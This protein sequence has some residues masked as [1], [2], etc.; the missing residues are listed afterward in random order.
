MTVTVEPRRGG[1][2]IVGS[3]GGGKGGGSSRTPVETPDS[4]HNSAYAAVLDVIGNGEMYGPVHRDQ[5]LRDVFLDGTP[6]QNEDGSLNFSQVQADYRVGTVDQEHIAGFPASANTIG[7][8]AEIKTD[9][10]WV[11]AI[12]N[13][14]LSAVRVTMYVPRLVQALESGKNAGDRVGYRV[15]YAIDLAV[16]GGSFQEVVRSA[17]DGK[18]SNGYTRTHRLD[19]PA[20]ASSWT[21]RAR[22]ITPEA[23][24]AAISDSISVQSYAEVIDG[25]FRHPMTAMMGIKI[26][27]E[28][29]QAI[30]TRAYRWRG[31]IIRIPSNYDPI[32]RTYAGVWD[33]TFKRGWSNNPAW[34]YYDMLTSR[35]YGL[36]DR[37][38]ASMID[39]Y[40]LYQIGAYCDQLVPDGQGGVEPRFVCNVY[41]QSAADALRVLNDLTS[42]FRGMAYWANGQVVASVDAPSD[43]IYTYTNA[44]VVGGRFEYA[45]ADLRTLKTVALVSW[46]DPS[47]FYRPKVEVVEDEDGIRRYGIRKTEVVAFGC[48]SRG[49]AQRVGLYQL[50]TSRMESGGLT[51]SVGLDGV[52]PQPGSIVRVADRNRAGRHIGGR[53]RQATAGTVTVDREH[54]IKAGDFLT[55]NLASGL[56]ETRAV[57][58]VSGRV[59]TVFPEFSQAPEPESVWSVDA[60]DLVTQHARILSVKEAGGIV[61]DVSAVLHHP[62]KFDAIDNGVRLDPL[63]V[64]VVPPRVQTAPTN[65]RIE[66]HYTIHQGTTR[67]Y[68]EISWDAAEHA[69]LYDVQWRRDN[70]DWVLVPRTGSRLVE[71]P[72]IYAGTYTVRVRA[73]NALDVPSLWA[74]STATLLDGLVGSPP[75]VTSL[76]AAGETL[77][78]RLTWAYPTTPNIVER[79]QIWSSETQQ[80]DSGRVLTNLAYPDTTYTLGNQRAGV[81]QWFWARLVDKNGLPG[82][83]YPGESESGVRGSADIDSGPILDLI[84][85]DVLSSAW[86]QQMAERVE[87]ID[88]R[89]LALRA[90]AGAADEL[91]QRVRADVER[92]RQQIAGA[93]KTIQKHAEDLR[94]Q[95]DQLV[96]NAADI[97]QVAADRV[98][99]DQ[100]QADAL[101]VETAA[102][103]VVQQQHAEDIAGNAEATRRVAADLLLENQGRTEQV[104]QEAALRVAGD[105][106]QADA[107]AAEGANR[108]AGDLAQAGALADAR[109]ELQDAIDGLAERVSDAAGDFSGLSARLT[110]EITDRTQ[111]AQAL[112]DDVL[113]NAS[114]IESAQAGLGDAVAR[115]T[116]AEQLQVDHAAQLLQLNVKADDASSGIDLLRDVQADQALNMLALRTDVDGNAATANQLLQ[117]T[118]ELSVAQS[119]LAV[120]A[121]NLEARADSLTEVADDH[122]LELLRLRASE[123]DAEGMYTS[124][125]RADARQVQRMERLQLQADGQQSQIEDIATVQVGH[126]ERI[127]TVETQAASVLSRVQVVETATETQASRLETVERQSGETSSRVAQMQIA[128]ESQASLLAD[129]RTDV[130]GNTSTAAQLLQTTNEL[131][132]QQTQLET[133]VG[134]AESQLHTVSGTQADHASMLVALRTDVTGN[135]NTAAQLLET[136]GE[137]SAAQTQ[138]SSRVGSAEAGLQAVQQTAA[139]TAQDLLALGVRTATAESDITVLR[140]AQEDQSSS[141]V[142]LKTQVDNNTATAS[143]LLR[144]T[145]ELSAAQTVLSNTVGGVQSDLSAVQQ[146]QVGLVQDVTALGVKAENLEAQADSLTEVAADH[147]LEL[148]RLRASEGDAEGM[149][150]HF[151]RADARQVQRMDR[152]QLQADGQQSQIEDI[153]T[154]QVGH[155][156]R[157]GTVETQAAS[158]LSRVQ[159]VETATQTQ[160]SRLESV[161]QQTGENTSR[162][163]QLQSAQD[164]QA[165]LL[166]DLRTDVDGNTNTAAQLLQTTGELA[167]QQTQLATRIGNAESGLQSVQ[168]TAAGTAQDLTSLT[169]RT[170]AAESDIT[171]LRQGQADQ[172]SSLMALK[173]QTDNNTATASQLLQTT[174]ELSAAQTLLRNDVDGVQSGLSA[175]QTVQAGLVQDVTALGVKTGTLEARADALTEVTQDH[176]LDLLRLRASEGDAEGM[177][178]SL[179]RADARQVRLLTALSL[180]VDGVKAD[181]EEVITLTEDLAGKQETLSF[182]LDGL[183]SQVQTLDVAQQGLAGQ[184]ST[185]SAR[186]DVAQQTAD[187]AVASA[188]GAQATA[189]TA[190]AD[191]AAARAA[192]GAAQSAADQAAQDAAAA[193]GLAGGKSDVLIQ[194]AT[195]AASYRNSKTLWID[196]TGNANTPKRWSGSAWVAVTDKAATDAAAAAVAAQ[197]RADAAQAAADQANAAAAQNAAD[198]VAERTARTTAE[199]AQAQTNQQLTASFQQAKTAADAAQG[200]ADQAKT[201]AAQA[202]ARVA[203]EELARASADAALAQRSTA[204]EAKTEAQGTQ[205]QTLD[206][207]TQEQALR[208]LEMRA[209]AGDSEGWMLTQ[210]R[211]TART[212]RTVE[213]QAVQLGG[214]LASIEGI[215]ETIVDETGALAQ[216]INTVSAT[217]TA[218]GTAAAGAQADADAAQATADLAVANAAVAQSAAATADQKAAA[219][220]G[221]ADG[222]AV[223]LYQTN[224]PAA[225]Y[226]NDKTLWIDITGN[227]NTPKR[228]SGSAWVAVTDKAATDAAAA[229]ATA[230]ADAAA[231]QAT[232]NQAVAS[233]ATNAAAIQLLQ[234]TTANQFQAQAQQIETLQASVV[235]ASA[236]VQETSTAL[237]TL[238]GR[239]EAWRNVKVQ[240]NVNGV[241]YIAGTSLGIDGE[242]NSSFNVLAQSFNVM[243]NING[244]PQAVFSVVGGQMVVRDALIGKI[245]AEKVDAETI[246]AI[247]ANLGDITAGTLSGATAGINLNAMGGESFI[248]VGNGKV[249]IRANG[250]SYFDGVV[251]SR[252]TIMGTG[253]YALN[254]LILGHVLGTL[255]RP[256]EQI[257]SRYIY[258]DTGIDDPYD[259]AYG[260]A[261]PSY[262]ARAKLDGWNEVD[263]PISGGTQIVLEATACCESVLIGTGANPNQV[264]RVF[265]RIGIHLVNGRPG[266][267]RVR[268]NSLT[269]AVFKLT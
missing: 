72:D 26:S 205:I 38:D 88:Y 210:Q 169:V 240:T 117:T 59:I 25:K 95:A 111:Q 9:R 178:T 191:A 151:A 86:G 152:L 145:G 103:L 262:T 214:M 97:V 5:P 154:V 149:Y 226:R 185:V 3:G 268:L 52:I 162:V 100:A 194:S 73:I 60:G 112:A 14:E 223:V 45:G 91:I 99:G 150:T 121:G 209:M 236:S 53:I 242:G 138:L 202:D 168:Q 21:V 141:L 135:A 203:E 139:G 255:G 134:N 213:Q 189:N 101:A 36:G 251:I 238:D 27:A 20:G 257:D 31:Q 122:A 78:I 136:T 109:A 22:R 267:T 41:L 66:Q 198:I 165:S 184:I 110:Q 33:G 174:G 79:V 80:F 195:P 212:A 8:N 254:G 157:I 132:T 269:W 113:E 40:A 216:Q 98:A 196:T 197:Q 171:V 67:H 260:H 142:A 182:E 192:A 232:A 123:G 6:I 227:A 177:Y 10:P 199:S 16:G 206:Q 105:Q 237:A 82:P 71:L 2:R 148:L 64:S 247:S 219:A 258:I 204:L 107:L 124:L 129:L 56:S 170:E 215:R 140:Q 161:E 249:V 266:Q 176:A 229:A 181:Y 44:N 93:Q 158:A 17:F 18:T 173:T 263:A 201:A 248:D 228:W 265:L 104:A 175:V 7:V 42:T 144:T 119:A 75:A 23:N 62:G 137:L 256:D 183:S 221:I 84:G 43:P 51:F 245:S 167:T 264:G 131:A 125:I 155:A 130:N 239:I 13:A 187:G 94:A 172:A 4:L 253:S 118:G 218:A 87:D 235:N 207:A 127:G 77:S 92:D 24:N 222:K 190:V 224:T 102:R 241:D 69:V 30:P 217:A 160:A 179:I 37:I 166:A 57:K 252:P 28:Q 230:R 114:A 156:E 47:D 143:Q 54:P 246:S 188:A 259:W 81:P 250:D 76:V 220:A 153:A 50:Y 106:A 163:A 11:Q 200:T 15:E 90:E 193:A 34:V 244:T 133:R 39:R 186:T 12:T 58:L 83:W 48:T 146:V 32:A 19:L 96:Q 108:L 35:L 128:Q 115:I 211:L 46:N 61:F 116:A 65:V 261:K 89:M 231:A 1:M 49:Q 159:V 68:A 29:F 233:A 126:A 55:V 208:Q 70:G 120:R 234:T 63:P 74:Y 164:G 85:D 225:T 243:H 147:A 180:S